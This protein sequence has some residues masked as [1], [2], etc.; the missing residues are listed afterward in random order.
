LSADRRRNL[1]LLFK[2]AITNAARHS[3]AANVSVE[4]RLE[5]GTLDLVIRDDGHGFVVEKAGGG[6]GL[7]TMKQRTDLM[8]GRL[9]IRSLLG[10]GT[11]VKVQVPID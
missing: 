5:Q 9:E 11:E 6:N 8:Q 2:E 10:A 1:V 4:V 3:G 7:K